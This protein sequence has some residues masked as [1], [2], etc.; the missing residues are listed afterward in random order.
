MRLLKENLVR[1][2]EQTGT[3]C[4][5]LTPPY[6]QLNDLAEKALLLKT[7]DDE[8]IKSPIPFSFVIVLGPQYTMNFSPAEVE[9]LIM[10]YLRI[11]NNPLESIKKITIQEFLN[12]CSSKPG[13]KDFV[14]IVDRS[15]TLFAEHKTAENL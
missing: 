4:L 7:T 15:S 3:T 10:H 9:M 2:Q 1:I 11:L 12:E 5:M 6:D 13:M 8:A 14:L